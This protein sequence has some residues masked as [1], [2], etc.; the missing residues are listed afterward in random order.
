MR[1]N[2]W[3]QKPIMTSQANGA[4]PEE[5]QPTLNAMG[6]AW[7]AA[8]AALPS[9][10]SEA[11]EAAQLAGE[12]AA[13]VQPQSEATVSSQTVTSQS[14]PASS[15]APAQPTFTAAQLEEISLVG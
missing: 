6:Q 15:A 12:P 4:V 9:V 10:P 5:T 13:E 2:S 3:T 8:A 7:D 14:V 1:R 11:G